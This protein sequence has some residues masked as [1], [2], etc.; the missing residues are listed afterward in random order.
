V[1]S[2][3]AICHG[4]FGRAT[5]Y[6]LDRPMATHAHREGHLVFFLD[7][8]PATLLVDGVPQ[9]TGRGW[10]V[11][12]DPWAPHAHRPP[13]PG[14]SGLFLVLYVR[15]GWFLEASR[16]KVGGLRFGA[17][18]IE[19]EGAL[20][21]RV[22]RVVG[23]LAEPRGDGRL[24]DALLELTAACFE[25]SWQG[26]SPA[27]ASARRGPIDFRVRRAMR[28]I[29]ERFADD[30]SFDRVAR[31]AGL[32]RPHF[33]KMFRDQLGLTPAL[34]LDLLRVEAALDRLLASDRSVTE[35]GHE[36]GFAC[37]SSFTRFF[38]AHVG[39]SPSEYRRRARLLGTRDFQ[40]R[41]Y[42][43]EGAFAR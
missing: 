8:T 9:P 17:P 13:A 26:V 1:S 3:L 29:G 39:P 35:I 21:R 4:A 6:R 31:E 24:E 14:A 19:L 37:Q 16:S 41:C 34:Y 15:P 5:L 18:R 38:T 2:A 10:A 32:S 25:R 23:L 27:P 11:A 30:L 33:Y 7:G 42:G 12:I 36:L 28:L 22:E 20:A 43:R 40:T